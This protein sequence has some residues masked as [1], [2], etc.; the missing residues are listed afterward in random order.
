[1]AAPRSSVAHSCS[2][3]SAAAMDIGA[4]SQAILRRPL[5]PY[6]LEVA[7]AIAHS[8]LHGQGRVFTVMMARQMGKNE[9]SAHLEAYLLYL[10]AA[11]GGTIVKA[12]PTFRPQLLIS[13]RRIEQL[14]DRLP[15]PLAWRDRWGHIVE[16]GQAGIQFLSAAPGSN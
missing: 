14:L 15:R 4:F 10:H 13:K 6:Q 9:L 7:R 12:A 8:V 5:R 16:L 3:L 11:A 2:A 1:M